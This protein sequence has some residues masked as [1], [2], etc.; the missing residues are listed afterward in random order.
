MYKQIFIVHGY[1][2]NGNCYTN[3][4]RGMLWPGGLKN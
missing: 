4:V 3:I 2:Y 1:M